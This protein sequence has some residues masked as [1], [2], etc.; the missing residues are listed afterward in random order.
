M[1]NALS[2]LKG[3]E[4]QAKDG[5]LGTVSDFLFVDATWKVRWIVV[6][7]GG[8]LTGRKILIHP[9][10]VVSTQLDAREINVALTK[11]QVEDSPDILK[12]RPVSQQMQNDIYGYYGWSPL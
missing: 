3:F 5:S 9:S 1:L 11:A 6:D 12:D 10:A 8:W 4:V 7:T 2:S